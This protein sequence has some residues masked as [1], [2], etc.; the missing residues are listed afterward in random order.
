VA[1]EAQT[2]LERRLSEREDPDEP[3]GGR[4]LVAGWSEVH[5]HSPA[6]RHRRRLIRRIVRGLDPRDVLDA[7]CG[8]PFL[9]EDLVRTLDV[10][11]YGCDISDIAMEAARRE[12]PGIEFRA[13][14]LALEA[15]PRDRTFDLV[16]C[17]EVLEHVPNWEAALDNVVAM[18][19]RHVLVTVPGGKLRGHDE[20]VGHIRHFDAD[21]VTRAL[22]ARGCEVRLVRN[23]GFP[24]HTLY[25]ALINLLGAERMYDQFGGDRPYTRSQRLLSNAI[26]ALFFVNDAFA[27]GE[28]LI[29]LGRKG[30]AGAAVSA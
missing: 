26:Y 30:D 27:A 28:Q 4:N 13:L 21:V 29:V 24:A 19:H 3:I 7:G 10:S 5:R 12:F 18:S 15:W 9:I 16:I 2:D 22:Q 25:R 1:P 23:W 8:Q 17:S 14:D 11:G 20:V 6:P